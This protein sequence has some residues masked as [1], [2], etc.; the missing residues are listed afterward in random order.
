MRILRV[1]A[2]MD[3]ANGGPGQGIRNSVPAMEDLGVYN[4]VVCID[5][6][7]ATFL[8]K[9]P[10]KIHALGPG[11]SAW[12]YSSKLLP[13]LLQNLYRFDAVII[14]GLWLYTGYA[15]MDAIRLLSDQ[16]NSQSSELK[17]PKVFVMPHGMLDPYFQCA[18]GRKLKAIRNWFYWKLIEGNVVNNAEG[19]LFTCE[20]ERELARVPFRPY[21]PKNEI[22]VG[23]GIAN[24]PLYTTEM[25]EAFERICPEIENFSYLLFLGRIHEKKGVDMLIR[26][27]I[28]IASTLFIEGGYSIKKKNYNETSSGESVVRP[29]K[30][31]IAGPGL[32]TEYGRKMQKMAREHTVLQHFILFPG[33]LSDDSKWGA[34][35]G[36]E[37]FVLPSHQENFGI[38]VVESLACCKPVLI[39]NKINIWKE[40]R[41]NGGGMVAN[42]TLGDVKLMLEDWLSF[43]DE[44]KV[45]MSSKARTTYEENFAIMPSVNRLLKVVNR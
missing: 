41:Y 18:P 8:N 12:C 17:V 27:Y 20:A 3:P 10:F 37:A 26:A 38:A 28:D 2:S 7:G 42:D 29:I 22:N 31:V 25:R 11:K 21:R 44:E 35:Y 14:H 24:P 6:P 19:L 4:E 23:Y 1:I 32:E 15:V 13:W 45:Y 16:K 40:I 30:L 36:C 33:M 5:D 39:T 43:K 9:D 34:F